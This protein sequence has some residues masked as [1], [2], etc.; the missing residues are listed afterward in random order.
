MIAMQVVED[1]LA[2]MAVGEGEEGAEAV[3][4]APLEKLT[5]PGDDGFSPA[6]CEGAAALRSVG[7]ERSKKWG[8]DERVQRGP[9]RRYRAA[10][11]EQGFW[12]VQNNKFGG[13]RYGISSAHR[14]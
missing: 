10:L 11:L 13:G 9:C 4:A 7:S 2:A 6:V 12:V 14:P 5:L 8:L 1:G 3:P